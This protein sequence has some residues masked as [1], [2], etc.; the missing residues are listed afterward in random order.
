MEVIKD[1]WKVYQ[2]Y[3]GEVQ[4]DPMEGIESEVGPSYYIKSLN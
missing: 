2:K 1:E 3:K 4:L